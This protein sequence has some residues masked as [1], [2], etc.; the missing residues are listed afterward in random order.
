MQGIRHCIHRSCFLDAVEVRCEHCNGSGFKP[1]VLKYKL[2][3]KNITDIL[4][5]TINEAN[6]F[7]VTR[8]SINHSI[9]FVKWAWTI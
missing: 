6:T 4:A 8:I 9:G 7:F 1:E 5:M 3:D 2:K